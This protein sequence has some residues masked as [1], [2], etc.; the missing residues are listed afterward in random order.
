MNEFKI[1]ELCVSEQINTIIKS[2]KFSRRSHNTEHSPTKLILY[3]TDTLLADKELEQNSDICLFKY[4]KIYL[5]IFDNNSSKQYKNFTVMP[6]YND[7]SPIERRF[8]ATIS[9]NYNK[10]IKKSNEHDII[11]TTY[12]NFRSW[13]IDNS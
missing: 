6:Q 1:K 8:L 10:I 2:N 4:G 3:A 9:P 5:I 13:F 7:L 12:F 11:I